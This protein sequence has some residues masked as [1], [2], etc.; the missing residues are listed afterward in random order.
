MT[1]LDVMR[2]QFILHAMSTGRQRQM[3]DTRAC[4]P[5]HFFVG[6]I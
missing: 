2:I 3:Q 4:L 6:E 5:G 1:M